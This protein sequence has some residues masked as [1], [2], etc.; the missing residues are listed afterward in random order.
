MEKVLDSLGLSKRE[1]ISILKIDKSTWDR[2]ATIYSVPHP[3]HLNA[4]ESLAESSQS[5]QELVAEKDVQVSVESLKR[6]IQV[7]EALGSPLSIGTVNTLLSEVGSSVLI[8]V[9]DISYLIKVSEGL[10]KPLSLQMVNELL[11]RRCD[12]Q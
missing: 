4:L 3:A 7:S 12:M 6:V 10:K 11:L 1:L 8:S 2:W 9:E 5:K